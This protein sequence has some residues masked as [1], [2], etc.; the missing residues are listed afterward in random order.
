MIVSVDLAYKRFADIG[1]A[2]LEQLP[3]GVIH[4]EFVRLPETKLTPQTLADRI[5]TICNDREVRTLLLDGPQAWKSPNNALRHSRVCE[6]QLNTPAKTGELR[7]V[8]PANY[9]PFVVFS[10]GVYDALTR[11]GW[12]RL[13]ATSGV[14]SGRVLVESFPLSAWR[15]LG[16]MPLPAKRRTRP[17]QV[18]E[19]LALL[20]RVVP[21]EVSE[22]PTHDELQATVSGLAGFAIERGEWSA[23]FV[24]GVAPHLLDGTWREGFIVNPLPSCLA[25]G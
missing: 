4:C 16:L 1:V 7:L 24:A 18:A 22:E 21:L 8:K 12:Q 2:T 10:V 17:G 20:K 5:N 23:C 6:R 11:L 3:S 14:P 13:E 9:T 25:A 15:S 19:R